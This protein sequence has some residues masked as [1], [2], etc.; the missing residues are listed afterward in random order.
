MGLADR[1]SCACALVGLLY[2]G[3]L[4]L[5]LYIHHHDPSDF[6]DIGG[7]LVSQPEEVPHNVQFVA[8][9][10]GYDGQ[11][12]YQLALNPFSPQQANQGLRIDNGPYRHQRILYPFLVWL[13][14]LGNWKIIPS[15]LLMVNY[16]SLCVLAWLGARFAQ[17]QERHALWGCLFA[18]YPGF[19][20]T[21]SY[22]LTEIVAVVF[23]LAG[24]MSWKRT[25]SNVRTGV[26]LAM[27]ALTRET[28]LLTAFAVGIAII[29]SRDYWRWPSAV[30]PLGIDAI[31]Q[32]ALWA[33]WGELPIQTAGL[34]LGIPGGGIRSFIESLSWQNVGH[35]IWIV[36]LIYLAGVGISALV[37]T[38]ITRDQLSHKLTWLFYGMMILA[39]TRY[40]WVEDVAFMRASAEFYLCSLILI[41]VSGHPRLLVPTGIGTV[42][43]WMV[44]AFTRLK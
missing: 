11:F 20:F 39:M 33:K 1:P 8:D 13:T 10:W 22:D 6:I 7:N 3:V 28:T 16:F 19:L 31:W 34:L 23:L 2:L 40:V 18:L 29:A 42:T 27:A 30:L 15:M 37:A 44:V 14:A 35:R 41:L 25:R 21:L 38:R 17:H 43:I 9:S 32:V 36:E 12:Y 5:Q 4:F 24:L 26:L